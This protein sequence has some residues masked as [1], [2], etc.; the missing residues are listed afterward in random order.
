MTAQICAYCN[1]LWWLHAVGTSEVRTYVLLQSVICIKSHYFTQSLR[2][3]APDACEC[4]EEALVG[5][6]WQ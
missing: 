4:D 3:G 5:D 2:L 1:L 6:Q